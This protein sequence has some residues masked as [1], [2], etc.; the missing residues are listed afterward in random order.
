MRW[1]FS[2]VKSIEQPFFGFLQKNDETFDRK[3][4]RDFRRLSITSALLLSP[5]VL[6]IIISSFFSQWCVDFWLRE[7]KEG[8]AQNRGHETRE[9]KRVRRPVVIL[10]RR[11]IRRI[12]DE[13]TEALHRDDKDDD[14]NDEQQHSV[15]NV[16]VL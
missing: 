12:D 3:K 14:E 6:R 2:R 8:N 9:G 1:L 16:A 7:K 10:G 5:L 4:T 11:R 13:K 15:F